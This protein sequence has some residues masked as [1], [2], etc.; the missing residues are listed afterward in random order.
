MSDSKKT[1]NV[2]LPP[3][4]SIERDEDQTLIIKIRKEKFV[5]Q[6]VLY[7][8]RLD[9]YLVVDLKKLHSL[10]DD[11]TVE[12]PRVSDDLNIFKGDAIDFKVY[13]HAKGAL[14]WPYNA[15]ENKR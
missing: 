10:C 13:K 3:H 12:G 9:P 11:H 1:D 4:L 8:D 2:K 7:E 5:D 15:G 14:M 6:V